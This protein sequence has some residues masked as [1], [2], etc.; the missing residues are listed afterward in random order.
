MEDCREELHS[1]IQED[2][3]TRCP[4]HLNLHPDNT[5]KQ[6]LTGASLLIYANKQ[7]LDGAMSADEIREVGHESAELFLSR[8]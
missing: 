5:L 4:Y 6:R 1:L 2:V 7:D 8:Y 3:C